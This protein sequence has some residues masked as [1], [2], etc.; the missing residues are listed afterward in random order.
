MKI[1]HTADWHIGKKLHKHDLA[2]D[3]DLFINW[4]CDTIESHEVEVLLV[5]G[6]IFDLANP[7]SEARKQYYRALM[8][9]KKFNCKLI[10]TGGNHDSPAMLDAPKEILRELEMHVTGGLPDKLEEIL[11]PLNGKNGEIELVIAAVPFLRDADLRTAGDGNTYEDRLEAIR[12]GI[13]KTFENAARLCN[14]KF[15]GIPAIAMGHLFA[16]G[17]ETSESER[18]IQ[19][20]NQAAFNALQFGDFFKYIALGHIHKPQRVNASVPA[21]Y[22]G[23][24][25]PLSF[26][27]RQDEK[28][29]LLIDTNKGF[30]PESIPLPSFRRLIKISGNLDELQ[31]KLSKLER[32]GELESLL[33][34]VLEED[35]YNADK[36][37]RF[38][39]LVS[40][41]N[42][43]GFKIVKHRTNFTHQLRG[44][45]ELYQTTV[46]LED[47]SPAEVFLELIKKQDYD[48]D[49][50]KELLGTFNEILELVQYNENEESL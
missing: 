40:N 44:A 12:K 38:D 36:I 11:V 4:L 45:S 31:L 46:K 2:P 24:P 19:I 9:L 39:E 10:L 37:F 3:F 30:I 13:Q 50:R 25:I 5:S 17:A 49:T 34:V 29:V 1:L 26:S 28:R 6:D 23:S 16:A 15:P 32:H 27:E 33:E 42:T 47:L 20:G 14:Q 8:Q 48:E 21:Y 22:S 43:P 35:T 7:S 41:F 18:D